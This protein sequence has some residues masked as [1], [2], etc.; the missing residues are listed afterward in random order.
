MSADD[1]VDVGGGGT[2][3]RGILSCGMGIWKQK[4]SLFV[5]SIS[6][7]TCPVKEFRFGMGM[8][9]LARGFVNTLLTVFK[10]PVVNILFTIL[11]RLNLNDL[12][13]RLFLIWLSACSYWL[14]WMDW[15]GRANCACRATAA[16]WAAC[17][18][19]GPFG[20]WPWLG[21]NPLWVGVCGVCWLNWAVE[22][23]SWAWREIRGDRPGDWL[24]G[25]AEDW[26]GGGRGLTWSGSF[27]LTL[28]EKNAII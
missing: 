4:L 8:P 20:N 10:K 22:C 1:C 5:L 11:F 14:W 26:A 27:C 24:V 6:V 19:F 28:S 17:C 23:V 12:N 21:G 13:T 3:M 18:A 9:K 15:F 7:L 16:A 2:D 25:G